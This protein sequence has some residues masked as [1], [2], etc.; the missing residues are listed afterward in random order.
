MIIG[1]S[2][3]AGSGKDTAAEF[4]IKNYP[5]G[6]IGLGDKLKRIC[7]D[8]FRFTDDQLW[9]PSS[10]RN[11]PDHRYQR[12]HTFAGPLARE[13]QHSGCICCGWTGVVTSDEVPKCYLTPR[14]ALQQLGTEWGRECFDSLWISDALQSAQ[15]LLGD[16][17]MSYSAKSG[18]HS[19]LP[20]C[21][22]TDE[23]W[24]TCYSGVRGVVFSD[25]RFIN[26]ATAIKRA[27]GL[28]VRLRRD[29]SL[30]GA[31]SVHQSEQEMREMG[32]G[33]FDAVI[34][35]RVGFSLED[36]EIEMTRVA[37]DWGIPKSGTISP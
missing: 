33:M 19:I 13:D 17:D 3:P 25:V 37:K 4:L 8:V 31:A 16:R 28:L 29:S 6:R 34:D 15:R 26:E 5:F 30:S 1:I 27:G 18:L 14:Y 35:N 23:P 32:D 22:P 2:G 12:V 7:K 9:G 11:A 21:A 36:L 10:S 20:T 24:T